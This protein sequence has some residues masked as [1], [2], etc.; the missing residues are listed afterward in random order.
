MYRKLHRYLGL[1]ALVFLSLLAL[2]GFL[3]NHPAILGSPTESTLSLAVDPV[4]A[5][6]LFRGT[7]SGLFESVDGGL[8]WQE[9]PM[10]FSAESAVDIAFAP[11]IPSLIY[12]VMEDLG[13]VFSSDGGTIWERL[14][15]GFVPLAEGLRL[16]R[17]SPGPGGRLV[18]A[19]SSGLMSSPDG[20]RSWS[21]I[22]SAKEPGRDLYALVHQIHT[23]YFFADWFVYVYDATALSAVLLSLSGLWIWWR[24]RASRRSTASLNP[25]RL[26]VEP[27]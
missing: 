5:Q 13:V 15:L 16:K 8:L 18:L 1:G 4:N 10:L 24:M 20:G 21:H 3:L 26:F 23:G 22:G 6:H 11:D 2:S 17:L 19:T 14:P 27:D 9:V 7:R 12:V 25:K